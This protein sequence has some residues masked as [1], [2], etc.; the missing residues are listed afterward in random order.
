MAR[1]RFTTI[2]AVAVAFLAMLSTAS[3]QSAI[4]GIVKD[5]SGG[6]LPGVSVQAASPTL[7]ERVREAVTDEQ[8]R[9]TIEIGR[10]H[11]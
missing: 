9:Y 3:A 8:G 4:S 2:V 10:A 5:S 1:Q 7:I 6:I 11:V